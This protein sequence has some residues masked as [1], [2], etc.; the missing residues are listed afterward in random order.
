MDDPWTRKSAKQAAA[1]LYWIA[2]LGGLGLLLGRS[3]ERGHRH[4]WAIT[5]IGIL[6]DAVIVAVCVYAFLDCLHYLLST[7]PC[8]RMGTC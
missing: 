7:T 5:I 8:Q 1:P 2:A 3:P 4:F 6:V